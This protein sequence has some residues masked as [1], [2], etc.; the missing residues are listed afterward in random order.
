MSRIIFV[1]S[2]VSLLALSGII[3]YWSASNS[4][5]AE[6]SIG[7]TSVMEIPVQTVCDSK[8]IVD[9]SGPASPKTESLP[10]P[11]IC[12]DDWIKG[13]DVPTYNCDV[14]FGPV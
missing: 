9:L 6:R 2:I 12:R 8:S 1:A 11:G 13:W 4:F 10:D 5:F 3:G 7:P 14:L